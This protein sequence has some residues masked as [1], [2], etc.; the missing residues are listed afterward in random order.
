MR[1]I[2]GPKKEDGTWDWK[3]A[4]ND[5]LHNFYFSTNFIGMNKSRRV[6][7]AK[8]VRLGNVKERD[9]LPVGG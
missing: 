7:G 4:H 3:R 5:V 9:N 1:E 2:C 8:G 6:G